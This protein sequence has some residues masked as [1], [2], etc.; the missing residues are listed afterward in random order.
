MSGLKRA[1]VPLIS[2][3]ILA[4]VFYIGAVVGGSMIRADML[5]ELEL[6]ELELVELEESLPTIE[7]RADHG[8]RNAEFFLHPGEHRVQ[9]SVEQNFD[10]QTGR[11]TTASFRCQGLD[12]EILVDEV[13]SR[14]NHEKLVRVLSRFVTCQSGTAGWWAIDFRDRGDD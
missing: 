1:L 2:M 13:A 8:Y 7:F 10:R 12:P 4:G 9:I 11:P 6:V 5:V 14:L 3:L